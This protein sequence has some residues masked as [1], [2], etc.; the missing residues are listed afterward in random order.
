MTDEI[1]SDGIVPV[2]LLP[3][4]PRGGRLLD[5][6]EQW[7]RSW[8]LAPALWIRVEDVLDEA[9]EYAVATTGRP[10]RITGHVIGHNGRRTVDVF[11][12]LGRG[13]VS[14]L[15]MLV[16]RWVD[17][18]VDPALTT[19]DARQDQTLEVLSEFVKLSQPDERRTATGETVG[20]RVVKANLVFAPTNRLG[21]SR[22]HLLE[23]K[24]NVNIV[25]AP[26]DR[27][28]PSS[29]DAF[30]RDTDEA[31]MD[32][33]ILANVATAAGLWPGLN[34][35]VYELDT[36]DLNARGQEVCVAQRVNVRAVLSDAL[37]FRT[38][39]RALV[40]SVRAESPLLDPLIASN[41]S[42]LEVLDPADNEEAVARMVGLTMRIDNG[43]LGYR[44][45]D[46]LPYRKIRRGIWASIWAFFKFFM[47][48]LLAT[49]GWIFDMITTKASKK[50]TAALH[51]EEGAEEVDAS[52]DFGRSRSRLDRQIGQQAEQLEQ[53]KE[54]L[55]RQFAEPLTLG[56]RD[57]A[58]KMWSEIRTL[59]FSVLDGST[60][61]DL[62]KSAPQRSAG[63]S[64]DLA[65]L[66]SQALAT[67]AAAPARKGRRKKREESNSQAGT[68]MPE[69]TQAMQSREITMVSEQGHPKVI[70]DVG[71]V[72]PDPSDRWVPPAGV[73]TTFRPSTVTDDGV[74]WLSTSEAERWIREVEKRIEFTE[75]RIAAQM[76]SLSTIET[77]VAEQEHLL[78]V[79]SSE[80]YSAQIE[81]E[82]LVEE[83]EYADL[84]EESDDDSLAPVD[85][86]HN[87]S[88]VVTVDDEPEESDVDEGE[89][90][91]DDGNL[92][93]G[94]KAAGDVAEVTAMKVGD[95][96]DAK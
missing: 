67:R 44:R 7:T 69:T 12:E 48:K 76:E 63:R 61:P 58:P 34:K 38:A 83:A 66:G 36:A 70:G 79:A 90:A 39:Q 27:P 91:D 80:A 22:L 52:L 65:I 32:A 37:A 57:L 71:F 20:T 10:P 40:D 87:D 89:L 15:R 92:E 88:V 62:S 33:F 68:F 4:E 30:T 1:W 18:F 3:G 21:G 5:V 19:H 47:D 53:R 2:I 78:E 45:R 9:G 96:V 25:V 41:V 11:R 86:V 60:I 74:Q 24:W 64:D 29:F 49:P 31:R 93:R 17:D 13:E 56:K 14:I 43:R 82:S 26:E 95:S 55:R 42:T 35:S 85:V 81:Y 28:T 6:I 84:S 46:L 73:L 51:G 16:V 54:Q 50:A 94:S 23:R 77:E 75:Q 59:I 72:C 8:L